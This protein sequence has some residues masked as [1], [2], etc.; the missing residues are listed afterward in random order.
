LC[1]QTEA[2]TYKTF[3]FDFESRGWFEF[4]QGC[5]AVAVW[6]V[7]AGK[8]VLIGA[9]TDKKVYVLD[10]L[11]GTYTGSG[12]Y[13]VGTV[14]ELI[15]F[16]SPDSEFVIDRIQFELSVATLAP[17]VTMWLDPT[18]PENPDTENKGKFSTDGSTDAAMALAITAHG[19]NHY[20]CT[21]VGGTFCQRVLVEVVLPANTVSGTI[22]GLAVYASAQPWT[23]N[24]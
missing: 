16:E 22:R 15:D 9:R 13:P 19:A 11:T 12:N 17:V 18:D 14:R 3:G 5:T 21:P 8:K 6:E 20:R 24:K 7:A 4:S 23:G 10:D 2:G 1:Y